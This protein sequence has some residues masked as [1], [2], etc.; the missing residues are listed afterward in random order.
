MYDSPSGHAFMVG[1]K[2]GNVITFG[3]LAKKCAVCSRAVRS[4]LEPSPHDCS[5]N[6]VGSSG[7]MEAKLA[8]QLTVELF[9]KKKANFI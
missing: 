1:C 3:V 9:D 7:S 8:L 6:H 4:G 2:S 5:I